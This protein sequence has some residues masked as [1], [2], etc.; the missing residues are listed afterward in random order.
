[1]KRTASRSIVAVSVLLAAGTLEAARRPRYGGELRIE[2]RATPRT[3]DPS[4]AT[5]LSYVFE[6]LV[7]LD[8]RG[9]PEPWLAASWTHEP[10]RKRWIFTARQNVKL[11]NGAVWAPGVISV[12]D[13]QP[14]EKILRDLARPRNA[15]VVRAEDGSPVGTGPFRIARWEAEKSATL[16]AHDEYWG[17]RP[18]LDRAEIRMGRA[19][20]EEALDFELG[21]ADVV[22]IPITDLRRFRQRG[23]PVFVSPPSE[24]LALEFEGT[25]ANDAIREAVALSIDRGAIYNVLLQK[26]GE[27]SGALLPLWIGGYSFLFATER[28]VSRARQLASPPRTLAFAY[29][30]QDAMMRAIGERIAVNTSEAGITM[31]PAAGTTADVRLERLPII[32]RDPWLALEELASLLKIPWPSAAGT[33]YDAERVL[34]EGF[35]VIPL[36]HLPDAWA[37][38]RRVRDWPHLADVWLDARETP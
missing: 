29:D 27:I 34:L 13:D 25:L 22:E 5:F 2:T 24:I 18:Y 38:S 26:Q 14:I 10:A 15:V 36:F 32:S 30:R 4:E 20:P 31:R 12:A 19:L 28:D 33:P 3:P 16:T 11:H 21:K 1:M 8:D 7:R 6:T 35:R 37:L 17:G 23:V 9:E